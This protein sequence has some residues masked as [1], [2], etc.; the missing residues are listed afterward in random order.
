[1]ACNFVASF[2][3][4]FFIALLP[5]ASFAKI[6][7]QPGSKQADKIT[8]LPGLPQTLAQLSQYAGSV[9][10]NNKLGSSLFYYLIES[11]TLSVKKPLVLWL[12]G[13]PLV[14]SLMGLIEIGPYRVASDGKTLYENIYSWNKAANLLFLETP[15]GVGFSY[16]NKTS[17]MQ[18]NNDAKTADMSYTFLVN[19]LERFPEYK[20]RDFYI[21]G[22]S[23]AGHYI[24]QLAQTI[25]ERAMPGSVINLKG[26]LVRVS[27]FLHLN[28]KVSAL[29][30]IK[31]YGYLLN[32]LCRLGTQ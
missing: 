3:C 9:V 15:V 16:C 4:L 30:L 12:N 6:I 2:F 5:L 25:V 27:N 8:A 28:F 21:A 13:G 11:S 20:N 18:Q 31:I 14:S 1:M 26:L 22:E 23:Y 10:V 17:E 19:W 32:F 29:Q 24:P 7:P